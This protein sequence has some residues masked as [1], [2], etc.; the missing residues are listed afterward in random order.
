MICPRCGFDNL[1]GNDDCS[2]C[3]L[4]LA[5]LD[6][7]TGH[8]RVQVSLLT[9]RVGCLNPTPPVTL[10]EK[11]TLANALTIMVEQ[12]ADAILV[13]SANGWLAGILSHRDI[14]MRAAD[15]HPNGFAKHLVAEYMTMPA[16]VSREDSLARAVKMMDSG[17]SP[18][19]AVIA[20][21]KPVGMVTMR[22]LVRHITNL[23]ANCD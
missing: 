5:Q 23:C 8:D 13:V 4:D 6:L 21:G 16:T 19:L 15:L 14:L 9:D 11:S 1:P 12:G 10:S 17:D 22:D 3:L 7:P 20:D 2:R 18:Y